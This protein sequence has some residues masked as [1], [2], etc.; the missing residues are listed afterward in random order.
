MGRALSTRLSAT[1]RSLDSPRASS[2]LR[3]LS[4]LTPAVV[5]TLVVVA[6]RT[7]SHGAAQV[8]ASHVTVSPA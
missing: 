4:K 5:A 7:L 3:G 2:L 6:L 1:P 8:T